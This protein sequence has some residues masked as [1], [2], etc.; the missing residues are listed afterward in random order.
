MMNERSRGG[1]DFL[2]D[3]LNSSAGGIALHAA[4]VGAGLEEAAIL[5]RARAL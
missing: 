4:R 2:A 5:A 3:G 1:N